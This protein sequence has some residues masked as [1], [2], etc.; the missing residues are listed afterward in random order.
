MVLERICRTL[1][2][3]NE[4]GDDTLRNPETNTRSCSQVSVDIFV[5][6]LNVYLMSG[7]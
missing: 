1:F 4:R 2:L 3:V 6:I 7:F 5:K